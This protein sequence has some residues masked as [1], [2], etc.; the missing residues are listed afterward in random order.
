[1]NIATLRHT[2]LSC[3]PPPQYSYSGIEP[4]HQPLH[5]VT[6]GEKNVQGP[7]H[8]TSKNSTNLY[9]FVHIRKELIL[10][11]EAT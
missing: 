9:W 2:W 4:N 3:V 1:M 8:E 7:Y 11:E 6:H 5:A 10:P